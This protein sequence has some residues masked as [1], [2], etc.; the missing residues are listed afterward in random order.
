M[1]LFLTTFSYSG[2]V[3]VS[4]VVIPTGHQVEKLLSVVWKR[5]AELLK[6]VHVVEAMMMMLVMAL[7][8]LTKKRVL[9]TM[10]VMFWF[11]SF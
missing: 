2:N 1:F 11:P 9:M 4:Q 3:N 6:L 5:N 8:G 7:C 10:L